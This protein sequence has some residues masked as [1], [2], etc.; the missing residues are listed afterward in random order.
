MYACLIEPLVALAAGRKTAYQQGKRL[1]VSTVREFGAQAE[2]L[3][4][5]P[6]EKPLKEP[7]EWL[8]RWMHR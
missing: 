5:Y 3:G 8:E 1:E 6:E 4:F 2:K 7:P